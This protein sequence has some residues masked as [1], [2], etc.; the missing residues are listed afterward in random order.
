MYSQQ[1]LS[2]AECPV[3]RMA[4][5]PVRALVFPSPQDQTVQP[6]LAPKTQEENNREGFPSKGSWGLGPEGLEE[7][8]GGGEGY[9]LHTGKK[10]L[11]SL[12][13][14]GVV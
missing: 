3:D 10:I 8:E 7:A 4:Q 12:Q 13:S 14:Q 2:P 9:S 6:G 1:V 11:L 5:G